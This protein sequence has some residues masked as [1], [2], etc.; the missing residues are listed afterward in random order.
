M[1]T[2]P[3]PVVFVHGLWLHA[4]SWRRLGGP[5]YREAG[6]RAGPRPGWPGDGDDGR[7]GLEGERRARRRAAGSTRSWQQYTSAIGEARLDADRDRAFVRRPDRPAAPRRRR[8]EGRRGDRSRPDQGRP[9]PAALRLPVASIALRNPANKKRAVSLTADQFHTALSK[10]GALRRALRGTV[11]EM[12]DPSSPGRPLEAAL[13]NFTGAAR[14]RRSTPQTQPARPAP[15]HRRRQGSAPSRHDQPRDRQAQANNS[16]AITDLKEFP[17]R[18]HSLTIDPGWE[19][20]ADAALAWRRARGRSVIWSW[21][22]VRHAGSACE[23]SAMKPCELMLIG[24]EPGSCPARRAASRWS[25][26]KTANRSGRPPMI[27]IAIGSPSVPAR[28]ADSGAPPTAT[29]T[30]RGSWSGRG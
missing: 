24:S 26:A 15:R 17:K 8:R 4:S 3:T 25:S 6:L 27:A 7:G 1:A 30:G 5:V 14:P 12:D 22:Q 10:P 23:V 20:V 9:A 2:E 21:E 28:T 19:E 11:R 18:G 16:P 29:Q 13:A